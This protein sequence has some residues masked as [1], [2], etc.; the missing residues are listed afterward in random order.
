MNRAA[1][2]LTAFHLIGDRSGLPAEKTGRKQLRPALFAAYRDLSQLRYDF[3]MILVDGD[4][5]FEW[6]KSLA[7]TIDATLHE[8]APQGIEGEQSRRQLLSLEQEIRNLVAQG[9]TGA[10]SVLWDRATCKLLSGVD[11]PMAGALRKNC[12]IYFVPI[13][14]APP[15]PA[16]PGTSKVH[17]A[18]PIRLCLISRPWPAF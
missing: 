10:L 17:W 16:A 7:D 2:T 9:Q 12:R 13:T 14:C 11:E 8:I 5:G 15:R 4:P 18:P 6:I 3:P 1:S